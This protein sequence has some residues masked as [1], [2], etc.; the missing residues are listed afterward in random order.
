MVSRVAAVALLALA[1]APAASAAPPANDTRA[2]AQPLTVGAAVTGTTSD[3]TADK[4]DPYACTGYQ[5]SV[6]YRIDSTDAGRLIIRLQA[7]GDLDAVVAVYRLDRSR[8]ASTACAVTGKD[9][10]AATA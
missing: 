2:N 5:E 8:L 4:T 10:A 7:S 6:W 9:G 1:L 3:A